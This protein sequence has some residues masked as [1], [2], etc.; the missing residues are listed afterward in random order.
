MSLPLVTELLDA[1][2]VT[3]APD[4]NIDDAIELLLKRKL[5][6]APVVDGERKLVGILSE[7]DCLKI[8]AGEA[9]NRLPEGRVSD[10]MTTETV[11]LSPDS[12]VLDVVDLFL[13]TSFRRIPVLS[14]SGEIVGVVS[15]TRVVEAV[16]A[17][18]NDADLYRSPDQTPPDDAGGVD[19][20][21]KRARGR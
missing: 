19:S 10:Y 5:S 11:T 17:M 1:S 20:A 7:K 14:S 15:R 2:I 9:F 3:L 4:T 13:R 12:T 18:R 6:G 8:V 21:M 16:A